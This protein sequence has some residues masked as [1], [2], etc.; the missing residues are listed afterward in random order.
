MKFTRPSFLITLAIIGINGYIIL[1]PLLPAATFWVRMRNPQT[2]TILTRRIHAAALPAKQNR[3]LIP[4]ILLDE[5]YYTGSS[6]QTLS[7]GLWL[8][9]NAST[10]DKQSNTVIVGHRFT[11]TNP[12]G[13]FYHLDKVDAG[14]EIG[15]FWQ[16]KK[17]VYKVTHTRVMAS[18]AREVEAPTSSATLTLYTCTPLWNPKDRLV[19]MAVLE[20]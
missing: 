9:P 16:G 14:D 13:T 19:V 1:V 2:Q 18:S 12:Q 5:P 17:Y 8:R 6:T 20:P 4:A 7:K 11:Y 10:P 15:L 3:I